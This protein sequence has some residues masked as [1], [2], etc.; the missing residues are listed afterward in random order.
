VLKIKIK[1]NEKF[2]VPPVGRYEFHDVDVKL[3]KR[4]PVF[5]FASPRYYE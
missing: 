3:R 2:I 4:L 1:K 5:S